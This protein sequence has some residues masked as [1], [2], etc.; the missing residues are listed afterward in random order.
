MPWVCVPREPI[1]VA[2]AEPGQ[3]PPKATPVA[4]GGQAALQGSTCA[5]P[6]QAREARV[7]RGSRQGETGELPWGGCTIQ[8][9]SRPP[10]DLAALLP[11]LSG[12]LLINSV[13]HVGA[14]RLQQMLF[15]DSPFL[16]GFLQQ[17]KFTGRGGAPR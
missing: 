2:L 13:F 8:R 16:Q 9:P 11:D 17:C 14:E 6:P 15:S 4:E 1:A 3:G 5:P 10:A 12:R 7:Q